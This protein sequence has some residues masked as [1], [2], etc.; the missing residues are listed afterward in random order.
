MNRRRPP[1]LLIVMTDQQRSDVITPGHPAGGPTIAR[2]AREGVRF[3][4]A[5]CPTPHCCPSRATFFTGLYPSRHGVWN[6]V[7]TRTV[8]GSGGLRPGVRCWSEDLRAAGYDL[9]FSGKWHISATERPQARGWREH[10]A[11]DLPGERH[12]ADW[13]DYAA[14]P[15]WYNQPAGAE[16]ARPRGTWMRPGYGPLRLYGVRDEA[17]T[18]EA[19]ASSATAALAEVLRAPG[20]PW[21]VFAGFVGPH[22][23]YMVPSRFLARVDPAL[24]R[25]P[26]NVD[27]VMADKPRLYARM[28]AA[29][30]ERL[31]RE[32][33]REAIRHYWA[34]SL[35]MDE[36]V[37]RL[38]AP[39]EAAGELDNTLVLFCSDHGDYM[40]EHGLFA[41]GV[42]AFESAYRV[43]LVVRWPAGGAAPGR[44]VDALVSLA[45]VG[46][47][48][49][50]AAG[51]NVPTG[52]S[53]RS[54]GGWLQGA[55]PAHWRDALLGQCN[56]FELYV[57]Q[58]LIRTREW[59]YVFNGFDA[60]ELYHLREDPF[61][62]R[63]L[64][65]DPRYAAQKR[66]LCG[67]LWELARAEDDTVTNDYFTVALAPV[68][69]G[70]A[71]AEGAGTAA[72]QHPASPPDDTA[73]RPVEPT[74]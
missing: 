17:G 25:L 13:P 11:R 45:D 21:C 63:N 33:V 20:T 40:G 70:H 3:T 44:S 72:N 74:P 65:A 4:Q 9:R 19:I 37:G 43:P 35:Y 71:F 15:E 36:L 48:L 59:K 18:D 57:T 41:K 61:E 2:L 51:L 14:Q 12:G 47:T 5:Y 29:M 27:D 53:G 58:R 30:S 66:A 67:R 60:D 52:L 50:E 34:Y 6:N 39:I 16:A 22:D 46:P 8:Q 26:E 73:G 32:E 42:P 69:P 64:A 54:L 1:N 28:R 23:P 55:P 49:L 7:L 68:G 62:Q 56:G 24:V 38:L 31:T 10:G